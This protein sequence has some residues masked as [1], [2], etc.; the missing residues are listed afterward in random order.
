MEVLIEK[1]PPVCTIIINRPEMKNAVN[2]KTAYL[3]FDAF[4]EFESDETEAEDRKVQDLKKT[5]SKKRT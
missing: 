4:N 2:G 5:A 1:N 3:L